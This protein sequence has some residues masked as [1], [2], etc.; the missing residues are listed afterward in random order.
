MEFHKLV[1]S[2]LVFKNDGIGEDELK[3][4]EN[5]FFERKIVIMGSHDI[6]EAYFLLYDYR[7]C[8]TLRD[9]RIYRKREY[10]DNSYLLK[11]RFF[12]RLSCEDK[13]IVY[14]VLN[15]L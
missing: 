5:F 1:G 8:F 4:M 9:N 3:V 10:M 15:M 14:S 7:D 13:S 11:K 6:S 2:I 12:D